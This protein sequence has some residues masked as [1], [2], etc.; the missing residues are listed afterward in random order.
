MNQSPKR[1]KQQQLTPAPS[2]LPYARSGYGYISPYSR[3][4]EQNQS[5]RYTTRPHKHGRVVLV[6]CKK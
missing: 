5:I 6:P 3:P 2:G 4:A 1:R